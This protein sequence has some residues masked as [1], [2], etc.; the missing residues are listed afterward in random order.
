MSYTESSFISWRRYSPQ[1]TN[2]LVFL[3]TLSRG[4][5]EVTRSQVMKVVVP[6]KAQPRRETSRTKWGS[7]ESLS[8][9]VLHL[10]TRSWKKMVPRENTPRIINRTFLSLE[11]GPTEVF[12]VN[13]SKWTG[14]FGV[15]SP[16]FIYT[17]EER[18]VTPTW[19]DEETKEH[20]FHTRRCT[21]YFSREEDHSS[22]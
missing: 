9:R 10:P 14:Y 17:R 16:K 6:T 3:W 2:T 21:A 4:V 13:T 20:W 7:L 11:Y 19:P 1:K 15:S 22:V 12:R 8:P 5:L 18:R